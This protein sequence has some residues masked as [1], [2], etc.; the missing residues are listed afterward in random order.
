MNINLLF[1][2]NHKIKE[3]RDIMMKNRILGGLLVAGMTVSMVACG[4]SD[5]TAK[6]SKDTK[7]EAETEQT[8]QKGSDKLTYVTIAE[9]A[10]IGDA[11][12]HV[13]IE[14]RFFEGY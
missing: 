5:H 4:S 11:P 14:K 6:T 2:G 7:S 10:F 1:E 12:L 3:E 8:T 9:N 13:A